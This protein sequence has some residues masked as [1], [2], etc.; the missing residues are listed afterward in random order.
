MRT[1]DARGEDTQKLNYPLFKKE[2]FYLFFTCDHMLLLLQTYVTRVLVSEE[3][4]YNANVCGLAG[5]I[6]CGGKR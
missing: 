2:L 6:L 3:N 1:K 4:A 5:G